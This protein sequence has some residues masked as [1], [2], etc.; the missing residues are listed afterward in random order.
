MKKIR[1]S[2]LLISLSLAAGACSAAPILA[3]D[4]TDP[5]VCDYTPDTG[6]FTAP[7]PPTSN[8]TP[9]TGG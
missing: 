4:C 1:L 9:D 7:T 8:Y 2:V 5:N 3:P 6:G